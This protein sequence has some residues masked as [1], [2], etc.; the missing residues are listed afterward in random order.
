[1]PPFKRL[2]M[3][4]PF[5]SLFVLHFGS[6][7]GLQFLLTSAPKFLTEVLGFDIRNAGFLSG[8]PYLMRMIMGILFGAVGDVL[9]NKN[10]LSVTN[11][12]KLFCIFCK[13]NKKNIE[14]NFPYSYIS[15]NF[16]SCSSLFIITI[17]INIDLFLAHVIPG[18]F[19]FGLGNVGCAPILSVTIITLSLGFNGAS[20]MT[21]LQNSQDLAPNF[22]GTIY[23]I[24]NCFGS[25]S[26]FIS[27]ALVGY[28]IRD[29]V[30]N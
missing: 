5:W 24:V 1:M 30:S 6:A 2:I 8:L 12:R 29:H 4:G 21:N 28:F 20:T 15:Y 13:F 7:W 25:A 16:T 27:P 17:L 11:V 18:L 3:S 22:A 14:T 9:R 19:L 10:Y 23:G 26:G